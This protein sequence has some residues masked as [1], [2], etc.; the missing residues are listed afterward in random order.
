MAASGARQQP[1]SQREDL[2]AA[3]QESDEKFRQLVDNITDVFWI[4]SPDLKELHY[5]SPGCERIWGRS[6]ASLRENPQ[7]WADFILPEDRER[8]LRAFAALKADQSSVDLEYRIVR[9]DGEVRWV[10][11]RG[12]QVRDAAGQLVR[13]A[14]IVTDISE[15]KQAEANTADALRQLNDV[16]AALDEA[17][18]VAVTDV[19]GLITYVND[20]FCATSQYSR[21]ELYGQTHRIVKSGFHPPEFMAHLWRTIS[22]GRVWQGEIKNRAKDGTFYWVAATIVPYLGPDGR[23]TQYIAIRHDITERKRYELKLLEVNQ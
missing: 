7:Q 4:R 18:I 20:K 9:P 23:P 10:R 8:V 13:H 2:L 19:N 14:G 17:A 16:K 15:R 3:L 21:A 11:V 5:L 22:S 12:F 6:A 1:D